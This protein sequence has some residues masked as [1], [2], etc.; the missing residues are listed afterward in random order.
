MESDDLFPHAQ[1]GQRLPDLH[2]HGE[3][4]RKAE[5]KDD[6]PG[7]V[8]RSACPAESAMINERK[9]DMNLKKKLK[10]FFT[11]K[12]RRDGGF[13][14]VELIVVI[15][16][17]AILAG[18]GTAG[19]SGYIKNA[20]KNADK[21]LVGD[22]M[23]AIETGTYSTMFN[24]DESFTMG[25]ISYPVGYVVLSS[26]AVAQTRPLMY[27]PTKFLGNV[28]LRK[29]RLMLF[30][31]IKRIRA[32]PVVVSFARRRMPM[33]IQKAQLLFAI[34]RHTVRISRRK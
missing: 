2:R 20:N 13:T 29:Q 8:H 5:N 9:E 16:I 3:A 28:N 23:R 15:A 25:G 12:R 10:A 34:A 31:L 22:I 21:A 32:F 11:L 6:P 26:N 24:L 1:K 18:V 14:L 4:D 33:Y 27:R 17:L 30:Q 7:G 19:Y